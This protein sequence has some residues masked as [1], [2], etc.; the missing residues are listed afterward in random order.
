MYATKHQGSFLDTLEETLIALLLG[1][2]TIITFA[3]VLARYL[4]HSNILWALEATVFLFAWL[5]LMGISY[6]VKHSLHLGVDVVINAVSPKTQRVLGIL[7]VVA[8]LAY[9]LLLLKGSWD[10]WYPFATKNAWYEVNDIPLADSLQFLSAWF[11]EGEKYEKIPKFI[12]YFALPLGI[13]L[14]TL[15]FV[16]AGYRIFRGTQTMLIASH[17][18]EESVDD[19]FDNVPDEITHEQE[20]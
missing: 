1:A 6:C 11:N 13:A 3:N 20:K 5:V 7:S 18:A 4:F 16:Q 10:Y 8:C 9:S 2:M 12:P 17:E 15:R 19:L 14:L